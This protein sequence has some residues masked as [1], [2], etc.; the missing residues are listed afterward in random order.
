MDPSLLT[1]QKTRYSI[2]ISQ[3]PT[4]SFSRQDFEYLLRLIR[5]A[6]DPVRPEVDQYSAQV[7]VSASDGEFTSELAFT[8]IDVSVTNLAPSVLADGLSSAD[9]QVK[10]GE[11]EVPLLPATMRVSVFEDSQVI[12]EVTITHTNPHHTV[13]PGHSGEGLRIAVDSA[14]SSSINVTVGPDGHTISL[15]GPASPLEFSQLLTD[16]TI[17]YIYPAMDSILQGDRPDFDTR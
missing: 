5:F 8:T 16:A 10:D 9:L 4:G 15:R 6:H 3:T 17:Y 2:A 11:S 14:P 13:N 12:E 7:G 1:L